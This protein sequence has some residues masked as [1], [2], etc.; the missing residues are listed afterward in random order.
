MAARVTVTLEGFDDVRNA[1][2]RVPD[3]A[4]VVLSEV[5]AKTTFSARQR[6]IA[7][8]PVDSGTLRRSITSSSRGMY[9]RV[10]INDPD[11]FYWRFVEY[12]TRYKAARP[13]IRTAAE[14]ETGA[15]TERVRL[16]GK[17]LERDFTSGG[18][19]L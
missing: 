15:F 6:A 3:A 17:Q 16:A 5:I 10:V 8:A 14:L 12:G 18:G 9:G 2:K 19:L 7:L 13:F 11:V 1:V 4:R